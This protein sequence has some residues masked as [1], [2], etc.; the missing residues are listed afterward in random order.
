MALAPPT[1]VFPNIFVGSPN[2]AKIDCLRVSRCDLNVNL[3]VTEEPPADTE[4]GVDQVD[5]GEGGQ[6]Q[7]EEQS[8][9]QLHSTHVE[10]FCQLS[11]R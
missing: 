6:Q 9:C 8:Y 10:I 1:T 2:Q 7:A 11:V 4:A 5:E 3:L